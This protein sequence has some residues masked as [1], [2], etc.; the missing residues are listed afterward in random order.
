METTVVKSEQTPQSLLT[1][2]IEKGADVAQLEKLMD[3]QE[4]WEKNQSR[5]SFLTSFGSFQGEVPKIEK[6]KQVAFGN[7]KYKYAEIAEI[8]ETIKEALTRNGFSYRW[9][10]EETDGAIK[11]TCIISH[12]DGHS[13]RTS[14]TASKD[15]SGNKNDIQARGSTITYLQRY[16][17]IGA[18]GLT[19]AQE[20]VDGR[21]EEPHKP[22]KKADAIPEATD[23]HGHNPGA[24]TPNQEANAPV[25]LKELSEKG[26][27]A[28]IEKINKG[29]IKTLEE[30]TSKVLL[31]PSALDQIN[32]AIEFANKMNAPRAAEKVEIGIS[33][34]ILHSIL[35]AETALQVEDIYANNPSLQHIP[36]FHEQINKR[37]RDLVI[38]AKEVK[39]KSKTKQTA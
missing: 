6:K 4:R 23:K 14:M 32:A 39:S 29:E 24:I 33:D 8:A 37:K 12:T 22:E 15:T 5:K 26:V 13:E 28:A 7:T 30:I 25:K 19:T 27:A 31:T 18:L 1:L 17:L 10:I 38:P 2:A 16:S 21:T 34:E 20:D 11:C 3:L 9:E 36:A 35:V